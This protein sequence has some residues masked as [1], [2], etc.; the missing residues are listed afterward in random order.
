[1]SKLMTAIGSVASR[2]SSFGV[3]PSCLA[4]GIRAANPRNILLDPAVGPGAGSAPDTGRLGAT[5]KLDDLL[6]T[7]P[8]A[9]V[10]FDIAAA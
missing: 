8:I 1:M 9:A 2:S 7:L 10:S 4:A 3:V 6:A 5:P